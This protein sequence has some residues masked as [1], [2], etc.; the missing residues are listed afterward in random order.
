MSLSVQG[1][2]PDVLAG[3]PFNLNIG[4][5]SEL[6]QLLQSAA[7]M[8]DARTVISQTKEDQQ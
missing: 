4:I 6:V 8:F 7:G 3:T 2:N 1:K 5:D